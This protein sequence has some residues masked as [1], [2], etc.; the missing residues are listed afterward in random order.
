[1][2]GN[3][4]L[5]CPHCEHDHTRDTSCPLDDCTCDGQ[6]AWFDW[7]AVYWVVAGHPNRVGRALSIAERRAAVRQMAAGGAGVID[8]V[9]RLRISHGDA[10]L[11]LD[12]ALANAE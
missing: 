11:Y 8:I 3:R 1:M 4:R 6:N 10:R 12:E 5:P 7:V 2:S 9:R